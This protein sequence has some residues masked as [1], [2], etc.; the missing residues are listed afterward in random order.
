VVH[1]VPRARTGT[2]ALPIGRDPVHRRKMSTRA[3]R[4]R[5]ARTDYEVVQ[6]LDGAALLRL[7]IHT[8]RT[9][10]IRVHLAWL[11]HPVAGDVLY[12]GTRA[13]SARRAPAAAALRAL[14]RPALHAARLAFTHPATHERLAF[15][16]PLAPELV[17]LVAALGGPGGPG[18]EDGLLSSR[19]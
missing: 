19:A 17:A 12:G 3:A 14:E 2:I 16:S 1:G 7:R 8:G 15:E 10:Q 9:H 5:T 13:P 11:G 18:R 6:A 4:A